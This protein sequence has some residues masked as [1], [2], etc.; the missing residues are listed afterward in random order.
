MAGT[1]TANNGML[2]A[3]FKRMWTSVI[4]M[5][6]GL[7][8]AMFMVNSVQ[9]FGE[10]WFYGIDLGKTYTD[11]VNYD[12]KGHT[13]G[14][15]IDVIFLP[16]FFMLIGL[17]L[18]REIVFGDLRGK[19]AVMPFVGALGGIVIPALI[20]KAFIIDAASDGYPIPTATDVAF[21]IAIVDMFKERI[22]RSVRIFI[23]A[24]AVVDDIAA[25]ALSVYEFTG[26]LDVIPLFYIG[27]LC[28][29][30]SI[31]NRSVLLAKLGNWQLLIYLVIMLPA[32]WY[33]LYLAHIHETLSGLIVAFFIPWNRK[34]R[35][36][37][38]VKQEYAKKHNLEMPADVVHDE[39][40]NLEDLLA[41]WVVPFCVGMYAFVVS[42][43][44]IQG[45]LAMHPIAITIAVA[46]FIGKPLGIAGSVYLLEALSVL[47]GKPLPRP[48]SSHLEFIGISVLAGIGFTMSLL[49]SSLAY[50][51]NPEFLEAAKMGVLMGSFAAALT[52]YI[53]LRIG[54][55]QYAKEEAG[56]TA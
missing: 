16:F 3:L 32:V 48:Q 47:V 9:L 15:W 39:L 2:T 6:V 40:H 26:N 12:I 30:M 50:P 54:V 43:V 36:E 27:G 21:S 7:T 42:G 10:G 34:D 46:L 38:R 1:N 51:N 55:R 13:F 25:V 52:G 29:L 22:S 17:E 11:I 24:L 33:C 53:C 19:S 31:M 23:L 56:V 5:S 28:V 45:E 41:E 4:F 49:M 20:F 44:M 14:H 18:K 35:E 8:V 37:L